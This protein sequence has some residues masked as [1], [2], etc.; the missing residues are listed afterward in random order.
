MPPSPSLG[1]PWL[2]ESLSPTSPWGMPFEGADA[3]GAGAGA[4][5]GGGAG[6]VAGFGAGAGAGFGATT[7]AAGFWAAWEFELLSLLPPQLA[8]PTAMSGIAAVVA[9]KAIGLL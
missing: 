3:C 5:A 2:S 9:R 7:A 6:W 8:A 4:G 1:P